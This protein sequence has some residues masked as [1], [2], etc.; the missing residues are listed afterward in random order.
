MEIQPFLNTFE[1]FERL[2]LAIYNYRLHEFIHHLILL[3]I[4][5]ILLTR[6]NEYLLL[7]KP[8]S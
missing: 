6:L 3:E 8:Y 5:G 1:D 7:P 4:L 2:L